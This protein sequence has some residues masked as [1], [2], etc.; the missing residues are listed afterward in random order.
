MNSIL[1]DLK[2]DYNTFC[3]IMV[4]SGTDYNIDEKTSLFETMKWYSKYKKTTTD[5]TFY[6]WLMENTKYITNYELLISVGRM[7]VIET[8]RTSGAF[9][10]ILLQVR[11][12]QDTISSLLFFPSRC[13]TTRESSADISSTPFSISRY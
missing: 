1:R 3:E 8:H 12:G 13:N 2:M 6:Q 11:V 4:L 5:R 9:I 7:F 10:Q